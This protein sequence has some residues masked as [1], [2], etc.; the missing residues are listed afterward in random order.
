MVVE[1]GHKTGF[2]SELEDMMFLLTHLCEIE[3]VFNPIFLIILIIIIIIIIIIVI[4]II[5]GK[6]NN[7]AAPAYTFEFVVA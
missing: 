3:P 2:A 6:G 4:I 5:R 1:N 7:E